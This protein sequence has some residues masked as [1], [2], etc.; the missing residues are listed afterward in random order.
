MLTDGGNGL[1]FVQLSSSIHMLPQQG[2]RHQCSYQPVRAYPF[3]Y[4][5]RSVAML[6]EASPGGGTAS[7]WLSP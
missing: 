7:P 1:D 3:S 5:G 2:A 6:P 4:L